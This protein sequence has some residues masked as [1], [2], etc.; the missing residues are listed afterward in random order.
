MAKCK[1]GAQDI[2]F[3]KLNNTQMEGNWKCP[4]CPEES[5]K[6]PEMPKKEA[7]AEKVEAPKEELAQAPE[8]PKKKKSSKKSK[9]K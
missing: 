3:K 6:T 2:I 7:P 9:S 4:A 1:C 5:S 8:V